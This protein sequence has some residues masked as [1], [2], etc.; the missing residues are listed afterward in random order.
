M[1]VSQAEWR[2]NKDCTV[3][4]AARSIIFVKEEDGVQQ[5]DTGRMRQQS[6]KGHLAQSDADH[7]FDACNGGREDSDADADLDVL[8][9]AYHW[10]LLHYLD[11]ICELGCTCGGTNNTRGGKDASSG[12]SSVKVVCNY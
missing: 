7:Y 3:V 5:N 2:F 12:C 11:A 1:E 9:A 8:V 4:L 6:C 10:L